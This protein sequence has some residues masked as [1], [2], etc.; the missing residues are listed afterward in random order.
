MATPKKTSRARRPSPP[1]SKAGRDLAVKHTPSA[2]RRLER[3]GQATVLSHAAS[4]KPRRKHKMTCHE[5]AIEL[6]EKGTSRAGRRLAKCRKGYSRCAEASWRLRVLGSSAAARALAHCHDGALAR[7]D[8]PRSEDGDELAFCE[9]CGSGDTVSTGLQDGRPS[10]R[11]RAC[12][13]EFV[14]LGL[15]PHEPLEIEHSRRD[16]PHGGVTSRDL[17]GG[18]RTE[19][20]ARRLIEAH[21]FGLRLQGQ[22]TGS[23]TATAVGGTAHSYDVKAF[24]NS[25]AEAIVRLS[26][27]VEHFDGPSAERRDNP[28]TLHGLPSPGRALRPAHQHVHALGPGRPSP[29]RPGTSGTV[30][31]MYYR[32]HKTGELVAA[33][34]DEPAAKDKMLT[35]TSRRQHA[36]VLIGHFLANHARIGLHEARALHAELEGMGYRLRA[37]TAGAPLEPGYT[38]GRVQEGYFEAPRVVAPFKATR[39]T[40][41]RNPATG[42]V[43]AALPDLPAAPGR[44]MTYRSFGGYREEDNGHFEAVWRRASTAQA[45]ELRAELE[46]LGY[47]IA[48]SR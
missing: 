11:C 19:A 15:D 37:E 12:R 21:R 35:Y 45:A 4:R 44:V 14:I 31:V 20:E 46:H 25:D 48:G 28:G 34:P 16:N 27:E 2:G 22:G 42:E 41:Y 38:T 23:V 7:R 5:A 1:C 3:C 8:N 29:D 47:R 9:A 24:G 18:T 39:V 40:F 43:A 17:R 30:R 32:D 36:E 26:H 10:F 33:F 6:E 13:A